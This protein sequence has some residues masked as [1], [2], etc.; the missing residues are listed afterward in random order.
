MPMPPVSRVNNPVCFNKGWL[1][2]HEDVMNEKFL[3]VYNHDGMMLLYSL[4]SEVV[5]K[6]EENEALS[7]E[8]RA[9]RF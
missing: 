1:V 3:I 2:V 9:N 7:L 5:T 8:R 4:D 6:A